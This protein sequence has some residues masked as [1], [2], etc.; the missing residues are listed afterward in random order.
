MPLSAP[1]CT[2]WY[3]ENTTP[4][5]RMKSLKKEA[6][7]AYQE[8]RTECRAVARSMRAACLKEARTIFDQ[9]MA[10]AKQESRVLRR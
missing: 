4:R 7:A 3:Q 2:R 9:T 10:D 6:G 8:A 5:A 1:R